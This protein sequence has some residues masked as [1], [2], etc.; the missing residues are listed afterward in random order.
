M[1]LE[2]HRPE[3]LEEALKLLAR[4]D[5]PTRPLGGGAVV[6]R[7]RGDDY[8]VV[9]VQ[10]LGLSKI[11]RQGNLLSIGASA[12]LQNLYECPDLQPALREVVR[13]ETSYNLRQTATL[14]GVLVCADGKSLLAAALLALDA[15]LIWQPDQVEIG[16]GDYLPM[17]SSWTGGLLMVEIRVPVQAGLLYDYVAR[18]PDDRPIACVAVARWPGGRTRIAAGGPGNAPVLAMDGLDAG[19]A[20][21]AVQNA[22]TH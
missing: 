2:Y 18:T 16:L 5:P 13:L 9:D 22:Y 11:E 12:S 7:S 8:A 1:I 10:R 20:D 21:T 17:R 19:G 4:T 6:S 15:R 14:A 3:T